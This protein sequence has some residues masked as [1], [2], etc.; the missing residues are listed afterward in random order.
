MTYSKAIGAETWISSDG[1]AYL[2]KLYSE[3]DGDE[4]TTVNTASFTLT[5]AQANPSKQGTHPRKSI[6]L[7]GWNGSCIHDFETPR[8]VQKRKRLDPD[9]P[10]YLSSEK[11]WDEPRRATVIAT[12]TKFSVFAVGTT[13]GLLELTPFPSQTGVLPL[14]KKLVLTNPY[15][16]ATGEV[17]ALDWSSDGYVLAVGWEKGWGIFSV[18]GRC[19]ASSFALEHNFDQTKCVVVFP[20]TKSSA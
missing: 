11:A 18:G 14:S 12:N 19:L 8:W 13:S 9:H 5:T 3:S 20:S 17:K 4:N 1:R 6:E 16:R 10:D 15:S 2:V 7:L